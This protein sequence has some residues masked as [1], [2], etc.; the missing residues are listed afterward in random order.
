MKSI[1]LLPPDRRDKATLKQLIEALEAA[2]AELLEYE[3]KNTKIIYKATRFSVTELSKEIEQFIAKTKKEGKNVI[4]CEDKIFEK[5]TKFLDLV[6]D[7]EKTTEALRAKITPEE[8]D[9]IDQES[10]IHPTLKHAKKT[11]G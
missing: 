10:S 1:K 6:G 9:K 2:E 3:T 7:Y 11:N 4:E 5:I 8:A